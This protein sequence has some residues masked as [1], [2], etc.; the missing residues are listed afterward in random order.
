MKKFFWFLIFLLVVLA[1]FLFFNFRKNITNQTKANLKL[2]WFIPDGVRADPDLFTIFKWAE[3]GEMPNLKKMME[4]GTYG[5]SKPVF[6]S[7]TPT[8]FATLLTGAY[9]DVH[10]V[11][12]GPMHVIG[13]PLDK[14][15]IP[16]FRSIAK[17]IAPIWETLEEN[18]LKVSLLSVPGSTP[19]EIQKGEV[20][21]GRWGGWGADFQSLIFES[22]GDLKQRINQGLASRLFYFGP[23]LTEYLDNGR[24][25][26]WGKAPQSFSEPIEI[27]MVGWGGIIYGYIYD[28]TNDKKINY[29]RIA[30]SKDKQKIF[31]DLKQGDW[32]D[33]ESITLKWTTEGNE[34]PIDSDVKLNVIKLNQDGFFR[35]RAFYNNM[36]DKI[37][38]PSEAAAIMEKAVGPM[39]DFVDN[40]PAQLGYYPEDKKTFLD[41]MNMTFD[42]HTK[43]IG[44]L[45]KNFSPN[46]V[47][48]DIYSPT[49]MLCSH[50]WTGF[51]DPTS[52]RYK[53]VTDEERKVLW[54][55]VKEMYLKLDKMLGEIMKQAGPNTYVVFSSDH[56]VIPQSKNVYLNNLFAK[57]GW[58]KFKIDAQTGESII[59][60]KNSKVI[61]LKMAHVY[62]NPNGLAGNYERASGKQYEFLRNEVISALND[63]VDSETGIKPVVNIVKWEEVK[64]KLHLTPERAGDLVITNAPNYGWSERMSEDLELFGQSMAVGYKQAIDPNLEGLMTP[65]VIVGPGVKKN[66]YL[67]DQPVNHV[68]QYPTILN[69]LKIK[70][71]DFVQGKI[72]PIFESGF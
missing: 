6:P 34:L 41:E 26:G 52:L 42:W 38:Q 32:S 63:L 61:Y 28:R 11:N 23:Q 70:A 55:E 12:D 43:V 10:G 48:H 65:F 29:D 57:K 72:L 67:G 71:P 25:E 27:K 51:I 9:P 22:K 36:N 62:I 44:V 49:V 64:E 13:K 14:V 19:P 24:A 54:D 46:I 60:W 68:D 21:R 8:N 1:S 50:W 56:G 45:V 20:F 69:G 7:H 30:F 18:G 66:N 37:V 58:L 33:W 35:I 17:K 3:E 4:R 53:E 15:A 39:A 5:Y 2:Y 47:I 16:G 31:S 59:D 40:F